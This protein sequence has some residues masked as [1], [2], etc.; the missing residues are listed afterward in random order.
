[1]YCTYLPVF[2]FKLNVHYL[3]FNLTSCLHDRN[4][5]CCIRPKYFVFILL[6]KN[7]EYLWN[8]VTMPYSTLVK[9]VVKC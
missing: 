1:M 6:L 2:V 9:A 8:K 5:N 7:V 4:R 3:Y